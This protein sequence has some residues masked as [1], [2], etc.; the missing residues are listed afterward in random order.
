MNS[1]E[2]LKR[3]AIRFGFVKR[4]FSKKIELKELKL[5]PIEILKYGK[6]D[7]DGQD[8]IKMKYRKRKLKDVRK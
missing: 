2:R 8:P 4:V 1:I 3:S 7:D 5:K 6:H